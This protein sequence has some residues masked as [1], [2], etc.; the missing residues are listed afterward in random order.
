VIDSFRT[1]AGEATARTTSKRSRFEAH[2]VPVRSLEE[3]REVLAKLRKAHRDAT[4]VCS[5]YRL[6][7]EPD[8]QCGSDDDGEPSSSA[9]M[10]ILQQL[11]RANLLDVLAVVVRH[12]GGVKLGVGGLVRA[13]AGVVAEAVASAS[14]VERAIASEIEIRFPPSATS[15][16]LRTVH[17]FDAQIERIEYDAEA[18]ALVSLPASRARDF[19]QALRE[20]SGGNAETEVLA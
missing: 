3:V 14:I 20:A 17:R 6:R 18:T 4:H 10:P 19:I 12:F 7:G 16:V 9:G 15:A 1:I 13:Y 8:P 11:E 5:A 2:L